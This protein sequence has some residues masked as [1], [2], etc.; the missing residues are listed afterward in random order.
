MLGLYSIIYKIGNDN[1]QFTLSKSN[2]K[3]GRALD[4]DLVLNDF[5]ISRHHAEIL[6]E[7]NQFV[8]YDLKSR[9]GARINKRLT[10]RSA[11]KDGDEVLL[12]TFRLQFRKTLDERV[13]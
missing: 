5:S 3:I 8:L 11:L 10:S 6:L 9:N 12:G 2:I 4:N 1:K 13:I 7:E